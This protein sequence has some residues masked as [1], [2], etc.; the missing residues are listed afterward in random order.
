MKLSNFD[1][2]LPTELIAQTPL[3]E[4]TDSR[5]MVLN[6]KDLTIC[7]DLFKNLVNYLNPGDLLVM[8][9][10]RVLPA[11]LFGEI[12]N[13]AKKVEVFLLK[14]IEKNPNG[15][16]WECL[17]RPGKKMQK[18][19]EINFT[20]EFSGSVIQI[21]EDGT[22]LIK[23][24]QTDI[25]PFLDEEGEMPLPPYI[26]EKLEEKERYQTVYSDKL[27]SVAAPTA[28]LHFTE[29]YLNKLKTKGV[30]IGFVTLDVGLGTFLPVKT[31]DIKE[32]K[33]HS[34]KYEI[35]QQLVD[36]INQTKKLGKKVIAVGTTSMR[37]LESSL[38]QNGNLIAQ[39]GETDI[40]IYPPYDFKV[41][42]ALL[43]NF[44]LPK[45]T[46]LMLVSALAGKEF[47]FEAYQ[48]AVNLKYRFF[49]FG[50]AMLIE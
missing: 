17:V 41:V 42:D 39:K 31:D 49:S 13:Y 26:K 37:V 8:N 18:G 2:H 10:T 20:Q 30:E 14:E 22:R 48:K 23:F 19:V 6:K 32:H 1:Y 12:K 35:K 36:R 47:M 45:S 16:V 38:D 46:L 3:E 4:R 25:Y 28:G 43:T 34:E 5:L 15:V 27:G 21:N 7:D 44:H 40:F 50:D 9:N 29:D 24:N 11:R 33:M